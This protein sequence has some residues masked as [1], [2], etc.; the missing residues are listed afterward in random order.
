[1]AVPS[2][3]EDGNAPTVAA[4]RGGVVNGGRHHRWNLARRPGA[5]DGSPGVVDDPGATFGREVMGVRLARVSHA[6]H[7]D[8]HD[9]TSGA[10]A[11]DADTVGGSGCGA[12]SFGAVAVCALRVLVAVDEVVARNKVID[13]IGVVWIDAAVENRDDDVAVACA[14]VPGVGALEIVAGGAPCLALVVVVPLVH[15][16]RVNGYLSGFALAKPVHL[17]P[18]GSWRGMECHRCFDGIYP[19]APGKLKQPLVWRQPTLSTDL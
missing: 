9:A 4:L 5:I 11:D 8:G 18:A 17:S 16:F 13:Q 15:E 14:D 19:G 10:G 1:M 3:P 7:P 6:Q 12:G 2:G